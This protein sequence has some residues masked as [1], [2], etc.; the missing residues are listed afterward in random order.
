MNVWTGLAQCVGKPAQTILRGQ[1]GSCGTVRDKPST[2]SPGR[3]EPKPE[4]CPREM[5]NSVGVEQTFGMK[6]LNNEDRTRTASSCA[7][8]TAI[9]KA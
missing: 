4:K 1:G 6:G 2:A 9:W 3:L 8:R 5:C 7:N